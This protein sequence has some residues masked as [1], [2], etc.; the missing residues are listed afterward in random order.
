[1]PNQSK[2]MRESRRK[3][4]DLAI[5]VIDRDLARRSREDADA[6]EGDSQG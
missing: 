2:E 4:D 6:E 1:M 5:R 3:L